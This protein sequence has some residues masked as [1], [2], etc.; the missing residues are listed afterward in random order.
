MTWLTARDRK[1]AIATLTGFYSKQVHHGKLDLKHTSVTGN[2]THEPRQ[3]TT[4]TVKVL[5]VRLATHSDDKPFLTNRTEHVA[6][7]VAHPGHVHDGRALLPPSEGDRQ[8]IAV[9]LANV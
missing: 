4:A 7:D 1:K 6:R 2:R 8:K 3:A 5:N 9:F